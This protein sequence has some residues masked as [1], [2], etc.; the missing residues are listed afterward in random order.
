MRLELAD[1]ENGVV[2]DLGIAKLFLDRGDGPD[3]PLARDG[4]NLPSVGGGIH[5]KSCRI[6]R[7]CPVLQ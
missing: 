7:H 6:E 4:K 5:L 3:G 2:G 1:I